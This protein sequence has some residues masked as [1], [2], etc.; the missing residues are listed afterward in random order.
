VAI[1]GLAMIQGLG[2]PL[3]GL[4]QNNAGAIARDCGSH[5][6]S[7]QFTVSVAAKIVTVSNSEKAI[8]ISFDRIRAQLN[9]FY[10]SIDTGY[11]PPACLIIQIS[12]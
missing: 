2:S 1:I 12:E 11:F 10:V 4:S 5:E 7:R 6:D 3:I 9:S 8:M